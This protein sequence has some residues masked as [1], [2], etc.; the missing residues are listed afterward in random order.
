MP[1][2]RILLV[3]TLTEIEWRIKPELE[4]WAEVASFD[5]PGVGEEPARE[6]P[7]LDGLRERG[8]EELDRLGWD[9]FVVAGDEYGGFTA[10]RV[11][12]ARRDRLAGF[13]YGHATLSLDQ[14]GERA[15]LNL[16][17]MTAFR[18]LA[19][20]DYRSYVRAL[21]QLTR[22]AYDDETADE[23]MRRVPQEV[24]L[25]YL[26]RVME[27][28]AQESSEEL[29]RGLGCPLLLAKHEGCLG[30]TDEGYEDAVAA[31]PEA[32]TVA[33]T[34]KPSVS[35]EFAA[36]LREFCEELDWG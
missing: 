20:K 19:D 11:A 2:P 24:T 28:A 30:W 5:A 29:L 13:A 9:R 6:R 17:V 27:R 18:G 33:M 14:S 4:E 22:Q 3:P 32:T 35:P 34:V 10:I 15:P 23:Y 8:I 31:F 21:T 26:P 36:K 1:R 7:L 12:A 16:E 25:S